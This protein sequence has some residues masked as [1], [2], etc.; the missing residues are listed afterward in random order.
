MLLITSFVAVCW[1]LAL[2]LSSVRL[3][4][5]LPISSHAQA[6]VSSGSSIPVHL[7]FFW[8]CCG[9]L[10]TFL[11]SNHCQ[12]A[13]DLASWPSKLSEMTTG[14]GHVVGWDDPAVCVIDCTQLLFAC[15]L[16][17]NRCYFQLWPGNVFTWSKVHGE[18]Q[19]HRSGST[20]CLKNAHALICIST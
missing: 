2:W 3:S 14:K 5:W 8:K 13:C 20:H 6:T 19:P 11:S 16:A 12:V 18:K 1:S 4:P 9:F 10:S 7:Q 15:E 17:K